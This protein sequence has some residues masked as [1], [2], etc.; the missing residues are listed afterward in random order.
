MKTNINIISHIYKMCGDLIVMKIVEAGATTTE[1]ISPIGTIGTMYVFYDYKKELFGV[2]CGYNKKNGDTGTFSYYVEKKDVLLDF[3][4]EFLNHPKF[5][6]VSIVN[7]SDL[8]RDSDNIT[9]EVLRENDEDKNEISGY[10]YNPYNNDDDE[11]EEEDEEEQFPN[12]EIMR[13]LNIM[14]NVYNDY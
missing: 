10:S 14:E 6:E 2:R 5:A 4:L 11:E 9:F 13:F 7:Y 12:K 1:E 8:P 3:L